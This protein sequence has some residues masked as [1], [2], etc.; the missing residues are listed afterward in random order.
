MQKKKKKKLK[1][2]PTEQ[3]C[4]SPKLLFSLVHILRFWFCAIFFFIPIVR[5]LHW[6][7]GFV[8]VIE[9]TLTSLIHVFSL[10][11]SGYLHSEWGCLQR[12]QTISKKSYGLWL[13]ENFNGCDTHVYACTCTY[14]IY[15]YSICN[16]FQVT[17][18]EIYDLRM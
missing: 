15:T 4:F 9:K 11:I 14:P 5:T 8:V 1:L 10:L 7:Y 3:K 2:D 6:K 16:K 18:N 13:D 12:H 17:Y